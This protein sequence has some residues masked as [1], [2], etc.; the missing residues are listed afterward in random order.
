MPTR[1]LHCH[2]QYLLTRPNGLPPWLQP[3]GTIEATSV[4]DTGHL[5]RT[6]GRLIGLDR[7]DVGKVRFCV[8][9][10]QI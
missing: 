10:E 8:G 3:D 1:G 7:L 6:V 5:K 2:S 4:Y 9:A